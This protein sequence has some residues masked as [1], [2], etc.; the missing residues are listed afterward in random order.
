[1]SPKEVFNTPRLPAAKGPYSQAVRA[2]DL[3]FVSGLV[4]VNPQ[5]GAAAGDFRA[6]TRQVLENLRVLLTQAGGSLS[7]VVKT[8]V[9]LADMRDFGALNEIY[10][11]YFPTN[12]PA[13]ST[14]QAPPPSG[15][16]VE[17]EAIA[18]LPRQ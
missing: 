4:G 9:F 13:R 15:F 5:T 16:L 6:Q 17:I 8:T 1:M 10:A 14:I 7:D 12:A 2:G 18:L 11:A 3:L